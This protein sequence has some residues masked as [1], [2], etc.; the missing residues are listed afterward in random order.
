VSYK[1]DLIQTIRDSDKWP[2]LDRP[3]FLVDLN[4]IADEAFEKNTVEGYL[5]ALLVYHQLCEELV[6][7]VLRDAQ[8]FIQLSV[9]PSEMFFP[10]KKKVM[11]GQLI[12][13]L[14]STISFENK[15]D[16]INKCLELNKSRIEIVHNLTRITTLD[17]IGEGVSRVKYLFDEIYGLFEET[18]D[19][20]RVCFKDFRKDVEWDDFL[21][22]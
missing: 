2:S 19:F 7:L 1:E 21:N 17:K 16:F 13:E 14:K 9:F 3:D 4:T 18:H 8:F 15:E 6:R 20:F 12:E 5:A 10:E 22:E 11:F